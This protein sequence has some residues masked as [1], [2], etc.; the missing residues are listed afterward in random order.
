MTEQEIKRLREEEKQEEK[1]KED[2]KSGS[3]EKDVVGDEDE[4][5]D[6]DE[7]V[8]QG[9]TAEMSAEDVAYY[10]EIEDR[11]A[12]SA[13]VRRD[14]ILEKRMKRA[15]YD[16]EGLSPKTLEV[17]EKMKAN[18]RYEPLYH[19]ENPYAEGLVDQKPPLPR[20]A[21]SLFIWDQVRSL[22]FCLRESDALA[23][24]D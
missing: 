8:E 19:V 5:E 1:L 10:K 18:P 4:D 9:E 14:R 22:L 7:N 13:K 3:L 16:Q 21:L 2:A 24:S 6:K 15:N 20:D 12:N 23:T 11:I 17:L